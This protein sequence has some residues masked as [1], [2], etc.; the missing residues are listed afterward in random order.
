[1]TARPSLLEVH[2]GRVPKGHQI[3][4]KRDPTDGLFWSVQQVKK[5][6]A[7]AGLR[8]RQRQCFLVGRT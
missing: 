7:I 2:N 6:F 8:R 5:L 3:T 1:M 4:G